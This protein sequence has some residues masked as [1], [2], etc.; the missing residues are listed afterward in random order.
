MLW[1][2]PTAAPLLLPEY[3]PEKSVW[4]WSGFLLSP[5]SAS[6][7]PFAPFFSGPVS[8]PSVADDSA[9]QC[10]HQIG[11]RSLPY[12]CA[13]CKPQAERL[14]VRSLSGLCPAP[15]GGA[16]GPLGKGHAMGSLCLLVQCS[17][18]VRVESLEIF[19]VMRQKPTGYL[20]CVSVCQAPGLG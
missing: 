20:L 17:A 4:L 19:A 14:P 7:E 16:Q 12:W 10:R 11:P 9:G 3:S 13:R 2:G 1:D 8:S 5:C 6:R 18:R 15:A